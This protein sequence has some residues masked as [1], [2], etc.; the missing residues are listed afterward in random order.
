MAK[1]LDGFGWSFY[2]FF[3]SKND[4]PDNDYKGRKIDWYLLG[5]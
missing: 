4:S 2:A 5:C 1:K 3:A